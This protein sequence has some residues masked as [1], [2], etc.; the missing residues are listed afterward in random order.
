MEVR[1]GTGK[2][3]KLAVGSV[4]CGLL[5]ASIS[6]WIVLAAPTVPNEIMEPG[7]QPGEVARYT[8]P[9]NCDNCHGGTP[10]PAYEP[11]HGWRGS[12]MAHSARDPLMW[13]SLAVAEQDF[14]PGSDPNQR[15]GVGDLCL[16][17]HAPNGWLQGRST[18]T[19]GS[20]LSETD[21]RFGVECEHCHLLVNPDPPTNVPGTREVQ[22]P[23]FEAYDPATGEGYYGSAQ[24]VING[25]GSRLGPY[26][27]ANAKHPW[28]KSPFHRDGRFCGTCHDVSNP[29]VGDLAPNNGAQVP[30]PPGSFSGVLG[31]P[32]EGK[33]AFNNPPYKYGIVER[34][35]S[36]WEASALASFRVNDYPSLPEDLKKPG[37]ALDLAYHRAFD[38]RSN[39]DYEDGTPRTFTC[40][41]C[42]L[43]ASTGVGCNKPG[44]PTRTD[45]PRHDMTGS[46]YWTPDLLAYMD[47][48]GSL[49]FGGGLTQAERNALS[50][51]RAR[52]QEALRS[53]ASLS[54]TQ[55]GGSLLVRVTNLTG[56]KLPSGYPEGRRMWLNVRWT[57]AVGTLLRED[58]AY[59]RIGRTVTDLSGVPHEV[60]SLLDPEGT[61][62]Y[63]V[64]PGMDR[65]WAAKLVSLGYDPNL[66]LAYD[67]R[68]D[69]VTLRLGELASSP[70]GTMH[71][72]F[73]FVLNNVVLKDGRIPPYGFR[74]DEAR[75]RNTLP[76]PE[77]SFGNPGPGGTYHDWDERALPIP[78]RAARAEVRLLYQQTSWELVQF[79]WLQNDGRNSFLA[80]AGRNLLDG[81]LNTGMSPPF[82]IASKSV[83]LAPRPAPGEASD[84]AS[85]SEQMRARY[86]KATG[87]I[88]VTYTPACD[89]LDHT[90]YYG[91]LRDLPSY[92]YSGAA[93]FVG[94]S[95]TASFDPGPGDFFFLIVGNEGPGGIE[96]SYGTDS[97]GTPRP[98]DTGTP[99]C[100]LPQEL[101][102]TCDPS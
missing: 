92:G 82:E 43:A 51:G 95:G 5:L 85:P 96:G 39:A 38:A 68:T 32:I 22:N 83:P 35:Y 98:E 29:A 66:P 65:A 26:G 6:V 3:N 100:D 99:G 93:C 63:D 37:G 21:D 18:P 59:G 48:R 67:R 76:V 45:L 24:Y 62:L 44:T 34:T 9:D 15:G 42:H 71:E 27:D 64:H 19:D 61:I 50:D 8:H 60:E 53:A 14:L 10:N 1:T 52:A 49:L 47:G 25:E 73:H 90:I 97:A 74:Y 102:S 12:M 36:E 20:A 31:S 79:L 30:L 23:P 4:A 80:N 33:A 91:P 72:T 101:T 11:N 69:A 46:Q 54:A 2:T 88:E 81:W 75:R 28:K 77:T 7:T 41:S 56:H 78:P 89:G 86:D 40:Q 17:C 16:R 70:P 87:W 57:D 58:G 94:K 84:P 13:A 55:S